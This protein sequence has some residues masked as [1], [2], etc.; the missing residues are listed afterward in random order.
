[1]S[2]ELALKLNDFTTKG[3]VIAPAGYVPTIGHSGYEPNLPARRLK[4]LNAVGSSAFRRAIRSKVQDT[5]G[6]GF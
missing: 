3:Y 4:S 6:I 5:R 1:M 2:E